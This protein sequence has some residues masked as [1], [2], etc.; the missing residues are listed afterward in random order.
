MFRASDLEIC[1]TDL[2]LSVEGLGFSDSAGTLSEILN[3]ETLNPKPETSDPKPE[4]P[5]LG[6]QERY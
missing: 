6:L 1:P 2:P 4:T 3:L 5:S